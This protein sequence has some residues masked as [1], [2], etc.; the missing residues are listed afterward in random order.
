MDDGTT[1]LPDQRLVAAG[2]EEDHQPHPKTLKHTTSSAD[3]GTPT[4]TDITA[5]FIKSKHDDGPTSSK[6]LPEDAP[7]DVDKSHLSDSTSITTKLSE[8]YSL[9]TSSDHLLHLNSPSLSSELQDI[10]SIGS[11]EIEFD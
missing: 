2:G 7:Q 1:T 4:K 8:T 5:V 10:S 6:P 3:V 11:V 9:N